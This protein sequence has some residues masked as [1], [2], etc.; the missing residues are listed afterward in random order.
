MLKY[1]QLLSDIASTKIIPLPPVTIKSPS[2][3]VGPTS[4]C[5]ETLIISVL[6]WMWEHNYSCSALIGTTAMSC[7]ECI[8][9]TSLCSL[10][11]IL[12]LS[13]SL[14][15]FLILE[16]VDIN[17]PFRTKNCFL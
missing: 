7:H 13:L 15:W 1:A 3:K 2:G 14:W 16:G 6:C 8:F 11:L 9:S 4:T 10:M 12:F 5:K 17:V